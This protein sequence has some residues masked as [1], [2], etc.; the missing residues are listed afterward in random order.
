MPEG[1]EREPN[2]FGEKEEQS[3]FLA[4]FRCRLEPVLVSA[5]IRKPLLFR[6]LDC[7]SDARCETVATAKMSGEKIALMIPAGR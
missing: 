7:D 4:P 3:G 6:S 5:P 1:I 2:Q